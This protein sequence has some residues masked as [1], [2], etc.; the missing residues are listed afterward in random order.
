MPPP[1]LRAFTDRPG[2]CERVCPDHSPNK[3]LAS[4]KIVAESKVFLLSLKENDRGRYF[5]LSEDTNG[6]RA[7]VIVPPEVAP[8]FMEAIKRL[9]AESEARP[10]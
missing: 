6:R 10:G 3:T 5:K 1:P 7:A 2:S 8:T 9:L 4:E